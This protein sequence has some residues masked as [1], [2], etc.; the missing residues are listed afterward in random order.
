MGNITQQMTLKEYIV[1][2]LSTK[3]RY[4][5]EPIDKTGVRFKLEE[6]TPQELYCSI[7]DKITQYFHELNTNIEIPA[8]PNFD[9]LQSR[10]ILPKITLSRGSGKTRDYEGT[11]SMNYF[12]NETPL[13]GN[14]NADFAETIGSRI[15]YQAISLFFNTKPKGM[16]PDN[17]DWANE[18]QRNRFLKQLED[19]LI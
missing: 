1:I 12:K 3:M 9:R 13:R 6:G 17:Y 16:C 5:T 7:T 8:P 2:N 4:K 14:K 15:T 11:I 19:R 18:T 10:S